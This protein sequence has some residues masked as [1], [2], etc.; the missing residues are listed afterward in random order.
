MRDR[1]AV[2]QRQSLEWSSEKIGTMTHE[3]KNNFLITTRNYN[4][5]TIVWCAKN[6]NTASTKP[7]CEQCSYFHETKNVHLHYKN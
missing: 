5:N 1:P 4:T 2:F 6:S 7:F 3:C